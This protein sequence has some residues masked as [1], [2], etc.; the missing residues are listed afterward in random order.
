VT[1]RV[2][3]DLA[4]QTIPSAKEANKR[5]YGALLSTLP[6]GHFHDEPDITWF[7][8]GLPLDLLNGVL[9]TNLER[10]AVS[11]AIDHVLTHFE[12]KRLPFSGASGRP[13]SRETSATCCGR[14]ASSTLRMS[15]GWLPICTRSKKT[16]RSRAT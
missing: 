10:Q 1:D 4:S 13:H 8:T 9:H 7:E 6:D 5:A 3:Q 15:R 16:R 2:L 14:T 12:R 11:A